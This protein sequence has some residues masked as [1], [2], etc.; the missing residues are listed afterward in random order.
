MLKKRKLWIQATALLSTQTLD[1]TLKIHKWFIKI[2]LFLYLDNT[3]SY[4]CLLWARFSTDNPGVMEIRQISKGKKNNT[5]WHGSIRVNS[6]FPSFAKVYAVIALA[7]FL[8]FS[9]SQRQQIDTLRPH[10]LPLPPKKRKKGK[11]KRRVSQFKKWHTLNKAFK[12][13]NTELLSF[14][15]SVKVFKAAGGLCWQLWFH[16]WKKW[17]VFVNEMN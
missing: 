2:S 3:F 14:A 6:L 10:S 16:Y 5:K 4:N 1:N 9:L 13:R 11:R 8:T 12:L 17:K 15:T 7:D